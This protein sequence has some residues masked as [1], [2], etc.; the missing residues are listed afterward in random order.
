MT[1]AARPK[2]GDRATS[3]VVVRLRT[4]DSGR[5][6][7][8]Y[9]HSG[10]LAAGSAYFADRLSDA[11]PTCQILDSRY[12]VEVHCRDADLSS[13]VTALRLLYAAD[14]VSRFGVRGALALLDAAAH[15]AC[16][17]TAAACA[18]YLESAPWDEADEEEILAAAP[19]LG[20]HRARVLA[21]LRPADPGPATA[22]FLS[23]FRHATAASRELKSAAQEQLEYMLTEDD[24]A[25]LLT[26]GAGS[27]AVKSQV[28]GCVT[29]LLNRFSDFTGSAL[30]K[31]TEAP[32]SGELQQDLHSFVSDIAWV[33]QVLGK[34][35]MMKFLAAYWVEASSAVVAAVEAAAAAEC[36]P[37][38]EC[39]K[40]RLKV[41]EISAKVLE[42]VAFGNVVLPAEKR[43]HAVSVW[44][45]FAG[46]TR[47]LVDE[48]DRGN[49]DGDGNNGDGDTEAEAASA[50]AAAAAKVGLDGEV[51][52]GL[53]SAITSIVTTLPSNA[54]AEVLSEWLQSK[55]AAF[56]DLSEAFDAW[57]Y[58]SKV[59]R[60]RLSF[61]TSANP[62]S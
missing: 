50:S 43:R 51:W 32:C 34:L 41:V 33:C 5:D 2:I 38:P 42:A 35:E 6:E 40:T 48:A 24:D 14:P 21:R 3:D 62:A 18:D 47:H 25:P 45:G 60:R 46:A 10:V 44:I 52:Q 19:R 61:L 27:D 31:Q 56:P 1:A 57:C 11:W 4:P 58:R 23:A 53:E 13:H 37:G 36:H 16:A 39:L 59:A 28:K 7:W 17:R 15:L 30:T 55:H 12:C 29:G 22:I 20:A 49:D 8:L 54:Q 9:C 26:F